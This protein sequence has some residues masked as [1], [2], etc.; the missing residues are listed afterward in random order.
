MKDKQNPEDL[1]C[2]SLKTAVVIIF[3]MI[4]FGVVFNWLDPDGSGLLKSLDLTNRDITMI[5]IDGCVFVIFWGLMEHFVFAPY[6][7]LT[8]ARDAATSG[9]EDQADDLLAEAEKLLAEYSNQVN[10]VRVEAVRRKLSLLEQAKKEADK[11]I[12]E[13][14][15]QAQQEL[16][17]ARAKLAE[18]IESLRKEALSSA[19]EM[20]ETAVSKIKRPPQIQT[21]VTK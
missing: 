14:G 17:E 6:L 12:Q 20:V 13:A 3:W 4:M 21:G 16:V 15:R 19:D 9:A 11:I 8:A 5:A 2:F 7:R 18:K 10:A 1:T